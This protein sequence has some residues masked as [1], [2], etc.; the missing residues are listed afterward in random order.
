M[1]RNRT[2]CNLAMLALLSVWLVNGCDQS[3]G[4]DTANDIS[5]RTQTIDLDDPYGGYNTADEQPAFGDAFLAAEYGPEADVAVNDGVDTTRIDRRHPRR[6]LMITW[7]NLRADSLIDFPT[8]WSGSLCAENGFIRV[9]RT[10]RFDPH[11][12]LLPRTSR[13]CVEWVSHTQPH[14]DGILVSLHGVQCDSPPTVAAKP[15]TLCEKA[16]S[17]TF[18]TGPL[19][20][21][22]SK[23]ELVNLHKVIAV[24]DDGNAVAFNTLVL[25]PAACPEGFLSGQWRDVEGERYAGVFRGQ[26]VSENGL[27]QGYLRGVYGDNSRGHHVFFGKWI[28]ENGAFRGLL[29]GRYGLLP[30]VRVTET[31]AEGWFAGVWFSRGLH[32]KG[33]LKGV[34]GSGEDESE[35]GFFRG[36]WAA[37]CRR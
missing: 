37:R 13:E 25:S 8:D 15:D 33:D 4:T 24:D 34:W 36:A 17:V 20:V 21:T 6:F 16:L 18:K 26:W 30:S 32:V 29:A 31:E 14:F 5:S 35:G 23:E 22:F 9:L 28:G 7:G 10:I 19:T 27:H 12:Y 11:D 2:L 3:T 1:Q